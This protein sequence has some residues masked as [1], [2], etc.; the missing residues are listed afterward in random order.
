METWR[1]RES[2]ETTMRKVE[3]F[4]DVEY[5]GKKGEL[6]DLGNEEI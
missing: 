4:M 6:K 3:E 5:L 2:G 1:R